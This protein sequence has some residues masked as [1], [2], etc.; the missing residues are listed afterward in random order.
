MVLSRLQKEGLKVKLAKC[1]FLQKE[2]SYLGH[3]ISRE[4][5][6]IDP[7]K[8]E[9][10]AR[11]RRPCQVSELHSFLGFASYYRRFVEGFAKLAG[12]LHKLV[13]NMTGSRPKRGQKP[14]FGS[15]WTT[16]V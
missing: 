1:A 9:A 15:A 16:P 10:V 13:A 4:C 11:W 6:S 5:V 7:A 2:V 14:G 12:P 3:V 8:I